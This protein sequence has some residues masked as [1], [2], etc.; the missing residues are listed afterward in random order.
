MRHFAGRESYTIRLA[1]IL[2]ALGWTDALMPF[3]WVNPADKTWEADFNA[4]LG[5]RGIVLFL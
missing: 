5:L 1:A 3:C 4:V 2:V